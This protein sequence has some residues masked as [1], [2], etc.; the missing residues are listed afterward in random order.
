M[1]HVLY[2]MTIEQVLPFIVI[3]SWLSR[4]YTARGSGTGFS[5]FGPTKLF[6]MNIEPFK[7]RLTCQ[8]RLN[9][10]WTEYKVQNSTFGLF[11]YFSVLWSFLFIYSVIWFSIYSVIWIG[12]TGP[13]RVMLGIIWGKT[14][15]NKLWLSLVSKVSLRLTK[16][17]YNL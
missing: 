1:W 15:Y 2:I 16:N 6:I 14:P 13:A 11:Y 7:V 5:E 10:N 3:N 9:V 8:N 17:C 12:S 4:C